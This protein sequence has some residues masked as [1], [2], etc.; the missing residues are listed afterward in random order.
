MNAPRKPEFDR[1]AASYG[2]L[3][4][5]SI[6]ASGE[7]P[8][9]FAAYKARYMARRLA[10]DARPVAAPAI[11]DFGC[12]VGTSIGYLHAAM[13]AAT[14]HGTDLSG[15]SIALAKAAHD[16]IATFTTIE[17]SR[18]AYADA[19]FDVVFVACVF[20]HIAP[21]QRP[22]WM[23]ELH[24]VLRPGG[25]LFVF[26][27]NLLNPLTVKS[28]RD[29]PFDEDAILLPRHELLGLA[30]QAGFAGVDARYIVFFPHA[31]AAL[32]PLEPWLG[33]LPLGA[34]YVVHAIA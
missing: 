18:L 15:A 3:H 25:Q 31:L 19:A 26:E 34:Q 17:D 32:R 13:P 11:L 1:Y 2:A 10:A 5:A 29:C 16:G 9:Y 22:H 14:L 28:V 33:W 23:Q 21:A 20:H 6:K 7:E 30:R 4:A 8:S 24:R 12:G 27:H